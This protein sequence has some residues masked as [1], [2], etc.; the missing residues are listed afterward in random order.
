ML[1]IGILDGK[2][3]DF[4]P[5]SLVCTWYWSDNPVHIENVDI[6]L[7]CNLYYTP[8]KRGTVAPRSED[9]IK[10]FFFLDVSIINNSFRDIQVHCL[11]AILQ[12]PDNRVLHCPW[13][14]CYDV[15]NSMGVD[16]L[17]LNVPRNTTTSL[18]SCSGA[19]DHSSWNPVEGHYSVYIE[20]WID[21][22]PTSGVKSNFAT[23]TLF[24]DISL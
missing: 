17:L 3:S 21:S 4:G 18:V 20:A 10:T 11:R 5:L 8:V 14:A 7:S 22:D 19:Q 1:H 13:I 6:T 15:N 24:F 2:Y 9:D 23:R 12:L 16:E